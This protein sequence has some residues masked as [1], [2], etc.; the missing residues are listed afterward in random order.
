MKKEEDTRAV[1]APPPPPPPPPLHSEQSEYMI[2]KGFLAKRSHTS[3]SVMSN[4]SSYLNDSQRLK[5]EK[6]ISDWNSFVA[7]CRDFARMLMSVLLY[8][9]YIA[10]LIGLFVCGLTGINLLNAGYCTHPSPS[11]TLRVC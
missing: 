6:Y 2:R 7:A 8:N 3:L 5:L 10:S 4:L 9:S 1:P 11:T